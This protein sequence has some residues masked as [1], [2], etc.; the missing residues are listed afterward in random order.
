MGL[1][2]GEAFHP[3]P[4]E[5]RAEQDGE[6]APISPPQAV[7]VMIGPAVQPAPSNTPATSG[8][9]IWPK[10]PMAIPQPAR[11]RSAGAE[12]HEHTCC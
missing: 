3:P 7:T 8:P 10:R 11:D 5:P 9:M 4:T 1:A 2:G 12:A 6:D